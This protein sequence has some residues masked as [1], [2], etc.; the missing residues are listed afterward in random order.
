MWRD[1]ANGE[2]SLLA[3]A[4]LQPIVHGLLER[5]PAA[6]VAG[7]E[8]TVAHSRRLITALQARSASGA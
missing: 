5:L 4:A 8:S 1:T 2:T 3:W 7:D 6:V